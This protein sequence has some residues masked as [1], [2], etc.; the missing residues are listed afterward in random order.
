MCNKIKESDS[1]IKE[2]DNKIK[3][4][5]NKN[6]N[7]AFKNIMYPICKAFPGE[8][9]IAGLLSIR[10]SVVSIQLFIIIINVFYYYSC[11]NNTIN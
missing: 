9:V 6:E 1:K 5:D 3:E 8:Q 7:E 4:S 11:I 2:S 10:D